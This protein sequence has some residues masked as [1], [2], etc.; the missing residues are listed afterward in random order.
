MPSRLDV[1]ARVIAR[2][3]GPDAFWIIG[4]EEPSVSVGLDDRGLM[5]LRGLNGWMLKDVGAGYSEAEYEVNTPVWRK[6]TPLQ[7]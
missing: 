7:R 4:Q 6:R 1:D 3:D 2:S 5:A